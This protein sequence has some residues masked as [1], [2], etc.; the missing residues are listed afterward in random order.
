MLQTYLKPS[1]YIVNGNFPCSVASSAD[2]IDQKEEQDQDLNMTKKV[3][4]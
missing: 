3:M 2:Q 4:L 1:L